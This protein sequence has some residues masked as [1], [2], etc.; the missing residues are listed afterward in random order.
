[1]SRPWP[2]AGY[3]AAVERAR[4]GERVDDRD[5]MHR[6][7]A[8]SVQLFRRYRDL[9]HAYHATML[10]DS[11]RLAAEARELVAGDPDDAQ[12]GSKA[13]GLAIADRI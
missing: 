2:A 4:P 10:P 1:M 9:V 3:D 5:E 7:G 13:S 6:I 8:S 12:P 11:H